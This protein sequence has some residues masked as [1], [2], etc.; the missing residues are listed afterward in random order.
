MTYTVLCATTLGTKPYISE[1][2]KMLFLKI[3]P[4][5][6]PLPSHGIKKGCGKRNKENN[7]KKS[8]SKEHTVRNMPKLTKPL[9][10]SCRNCQL[11]K[12]TRAEFKTKEFSTTKPLELIHTKLYGPMRTKGIN[13]EVYFILFI[14]DY[15]RMTWISLLKKK[16]KYFQV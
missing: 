2:G 3:K 1:I 16:S 15:S 12:Q 11:G 8:V 13:G 5:T 4:G 6:R 7:G 14:D 9:N 10:S